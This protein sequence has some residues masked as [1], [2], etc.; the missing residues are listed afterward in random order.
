MEL[1]TE[2][3]RREKEE[4]FKKQ[5]RDIEALKISFQEKLSEKEGEI[6]TMRAIIE[7]FEKKV[8][9]TEIEEVIKKA[10]NIML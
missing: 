4:Y 3:C 7:E 8:K 10:K 2:K 9:G 6:S 5:E 1:I